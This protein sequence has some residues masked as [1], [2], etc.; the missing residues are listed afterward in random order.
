MG[1]G[2]GGVVGSDMWFYFNWPKNVQMNQRNVDGVRFNNR[3]TCLESLGP[4]VAVCVAYSKTRNG[5][6]EVFVDN[7]GAFNIA[8]KGYS[9]AD[10]YSYN[11]S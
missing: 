2:L 10:P 1:N 9:T 7:Q 5:A 8:R 11:S 4:L 6:L 3:H